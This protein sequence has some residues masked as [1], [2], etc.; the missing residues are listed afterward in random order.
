MMCSPPGSKFTLAKRP[1]S[2]DSWG[3]ICMGWLE[4]SSSRGHRHGFV[5]FNRVGNPGTGR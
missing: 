3:T 4:L 5:N 2:T 1:I